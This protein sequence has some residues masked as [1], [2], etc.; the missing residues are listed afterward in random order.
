MDAWYEEEEEVFVHLR[1]P[2]H[3]IDVHHSSRH[4]RIVVGYEIIAE[5][6]RPMLLFKTGFPTRYYIPQEDCRM[7]FLQPT[8]NQTRCP[9]KGIA[10]AY[11]SIVAGD[12]VLENCVWSYLDPLVENRKSLL[13]FSRMC[14]LI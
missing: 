9:Y 3:R 5:T 12:K 13:A 8:D 7:E 6:R 2:Y 10:S 11:W 1:D 4:L 14:E